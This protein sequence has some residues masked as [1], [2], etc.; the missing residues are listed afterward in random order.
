[1]LASGSLDGTIKLWNL[2]TGEEIAS[3]TAKEYS[4]GINSVAIG[5]N[6]KILVSGSSNGTIDI[7]QVR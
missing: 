6:G 4:V 2:Q 1:M 7:W 5:P 3:L